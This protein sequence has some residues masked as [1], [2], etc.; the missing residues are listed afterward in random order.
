MP[1]RSTDYLY[2]LIYTLT[3]AEKRSCRIFLNKKSSDEEG[4]KNMQLFDAIEKT[5]NP[6]DC[7]ILKKCPS[8]NC[9]QL[10]NLKQYLYKNILKCL[11][12]LKEEN[13]IEIQ[14]HEQLDYAKIL[15]EKGLFND[16]LKTLYKMKEQAKKYDQF[17]YLMQALIF[18]TAFKMN[19]P[20]SFEETE[21][22]KLFNDSFEIQNRVSLL[23]R[24]SNLSLFFFNWFFKN[25]H[26]HKKNDVDY[27][28]NMLR[29]TLQDVKA[30]DEDDFYTALFIAQCKCWL[31]YI[32]NDYTVFYK[33]AYKWI[34]LFKRSPLMIEVEPLFYLK[35]IQ[36]LL[37]ASFLLRHN[38]LFDE[39]I[40][41][42]EEFKEKNKL[43]QA[44]VS[45]NSA[46]TYLLSAKINY[47][48]MKGIT[49]GNEQ[50]VWDIE[51][52][53]I[54]NESRI[55]FH[56]QMIFQYK[57]GSLF[58]CEGKYDRCIKQ[59]NN[60]L[61]N[62]TDVRTD[63][64]CYARLLHILAHFES[65]NHELIEYL[66]KSAYRFLKK[67]HDPSAAEK[68]ILSFFQK[69]FML[70]SGQINI[71]MN[72]FMV[73]ITRFLQENDLSD[74]FLSYLDIESWVKGK[75]NNVPTAEII[76]GKFNNRKTK[77][78][79]VQVVG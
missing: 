56:H 35:G 26:S 10:P 31:A 21:L 14:L 13:N 30:I 25:G 19:H 74:I 79:P 77:T 48:L 45:Y 58:F 9:K 70:A 62:K 38:A 16:S 4:L 57:L 50:L 23:L 3:K 68:L 76:K 2:D 66:S 29:L 36:Y 54:V 28:Q 53:M 71:A 18:E 8:L 64:Q 6:C 49:N 46:C 65:G 47:R 63:L 61:N 20:S 67:L 27:L 12:R 75:L 11:R 42:L 60:I 5:L 41:L 32:T 34:N 15:F 17:S 59:L 33:N 24:L 55:N 44:S 1:S 69:Y 51:N 78:L 22:H 7:A 73:Y 72:K 37:I 39:H 40:T 43:D 52:H